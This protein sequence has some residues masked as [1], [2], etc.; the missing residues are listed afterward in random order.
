MASKEPRGKAEVAPFSLA[1][2]RALAK[3]VDQFDLTELELDRGVERLH[4][5][6]ERSGGVPM[7]TVHAPEPVHSTA[8]AS[9]V[10]LQTAPPPDAAS[11]ND[12]SV[13]ITSPFVGTYYRAASPESSP[14]VEM[15]QVV[16]KGQV[17][18]IVEAMKLMN[19]IEAEA[20]CKIL[21]II[22]KNADVV[23][24]GQPLFK[25]FPMA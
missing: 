1:D 7:A 16:K 5:R 11:A 10:P 22:A 15:G 23:E 20:D 19:E 4:L 8:L 2:V 3:L 24:F 14:F 9:V 17:L 6:R 13:I 21:E 25:V 18:C 12:G